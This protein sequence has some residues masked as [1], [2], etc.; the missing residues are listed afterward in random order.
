MGALRAHPGPVVA[1][2]SLA[3]AW[4]VTAHGAGRAVPS[5]PGRTAYRCAPSSM[6]L[7]DNTNEDPTQG[8]GHAPAFS[9]RLNGRLRPFCLDSVTTRHAGGAPS[10][11]TLGL[12]VLSGLG[13]RGKPIG[14]LP[15]DVASETWTAAFDV[16]TIIDGSYACADSDPTTWA[17]NAAS[18]GK[19]MCTV[20]ASPAIPT[21]RPVPAKPSY[22]CYG[23]QQTLFDNSNGGGVVNG[24]KRPLIS[25]YT[26]TQGIYSWCLKR[27]QTYHFNGGHG[28]KPGRLGLVPFSFA[29]LQHPIAE[30]GARSSSGEGNAPDVNWYA[31]WSTGPRPDVVE[32]NYLCRDSSPGTWSSNQQSKGDGFCT[33]LGTPAYVSGLTLPSGLRLPQP[34]PAAPSGKPPKKGSVRCFTGT[35]SSMLLNPINV[36][37]D[38]WAMLLLHCSIPEKDGFQGRLAPSSIFVIER[39]CQSFWT[40]PSASGNPPPPVF[41]HYTGQP[42]SPCAHAQLFVPYVVKGAWRVDVQARD[43]ATQ[44][45]LQSGQ[46]FGVFVRYPGG[47]VQAQ[48][49]LNVR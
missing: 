20:I 35:L 45:G 18:R 31:D 22:T 4:P 6:T 5:L 19:G 42:S 12:R 33:V 28:Q 43:G 49:T 16:P 7:L 38:D 23:D 41:V 29:A 25:T 11:G 10:T 32:G 40:Y 17:Q 1:L 15:A 47:D 36:A 46:S 2:V 27:I 44:A 26:V 48:N 9:T 13:G 24:G 34:A 3:A 21:Q 14:P 8:G 39:G 30:R 37:P